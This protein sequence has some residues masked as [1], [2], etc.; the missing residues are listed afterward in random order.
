MKRRGQASAGAPAK[1]RQNASQTTRATNELDAKK[2]TLS[3][4]AC[5]ATWTLV[6]GQ[7][8]SGK[9]TLVKKVL[10]ELLAKGIR[11][12]GFYTDEVLSKGGSRIG[13]DVVTIP[14]GV[15]G[16][17][18]RKGGPASH[19][20]TGAYSVDVASFE[21]LALPTLQAPAGVLLVVDEVGRMELHSERFRDRILE[22]ADDGSTRVFGAVTAPIYG[23]RVLFCDDLTAREEVRVTKIMKS[24]RGE[25]A[26]A[27]AAMLVLREEV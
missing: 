21:R 20:R 23:H 10:S 24:N 25:V 26:E 6:T 4:P 3:A 8:G 11:C 13:F 1:R 22:L 18:C 14:D 27:I 17:L 15:R 9:T 7:P 16:P 12:S 19:P 5:I 2:R